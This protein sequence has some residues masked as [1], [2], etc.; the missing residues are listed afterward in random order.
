MLKTFPVVLSH[1]RKLPPAVKLK[2]QS[3]ERFV[4]TFILSVTRK[5]TS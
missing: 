1:E 2:A 5:H 3:K 4:R